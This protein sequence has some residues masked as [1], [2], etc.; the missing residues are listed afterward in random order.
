MGRSGLAG[1]GRFDEA[2]KYLLDSNIIIGG[3]L[4]S[5]EALRARMASCDEDDMV[6]SAVA[7]AEVAHGSMHGKPPPRDLLE[8][9]LRDIPVLPFDAAAAQA[10]AALS[11]QRASYDRLIAAH[12]LSL[13]VS[14]VT[15]N[16]KHFADV[17]GLKVENWMAA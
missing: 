14:I 13:G 5:S 6:T 8:E 9:F 7:Y 4:A 1:I 10:Y 17:P 16:E 2:V 3:L 15:A 12:A 11:F